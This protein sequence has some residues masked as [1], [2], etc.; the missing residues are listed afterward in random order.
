MAGD[1]WGWLG[2]AADGWGRRGPLGTAGNGGVSARDG[3]VV[4]WL[5][6][7]YETTHGTEVAV[8]TVCDVRSVEC[9]SAKPVVTRPTDSLSSRLQPAAL[10]VLHCQFAR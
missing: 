1:G 7:T 5:W 2:M 8:A 4:P 9:R 10:T 6:D 3:G